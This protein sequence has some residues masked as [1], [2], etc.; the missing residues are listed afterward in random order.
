M[1]NA[2][3]TVIANNARG[4]D[5]EHPL[6]DGC[7]NIL[8]SNFRWNDDG[9]AVTMQRRREKNEMRLTRVIR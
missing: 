2:A 8:D 5:G 9:D 4:D 7:G 6:R 1:V 3:T